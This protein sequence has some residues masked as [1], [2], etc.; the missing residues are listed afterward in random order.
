M[1]GPIFNFLVIIFC[2]LSFW[3]NPETYDFLFDLLLANWALLIFNM[4]PVF[5]L[6]AG[7]LILLFISLR[8]SRL[9][10]LRK[11]K[12]ISILFVCFL[13]VLFVLS[14]F[15]TFN[16]SLGV[17]VVNLMF[18]I[19]SEATDTSYKRQV[20][21]NRKFNLIRKGLLERCIY[22]SSD[23]PL[24]MLFKF[25]DDSHFY[26]FNFLDEN[27]NIVKQIDELEFYRDIGMI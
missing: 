20:F 10:A 6:D 9:I 27:Y 1:A 23:F 18:L 19:F 22:V 21:V 26:K 13:F 8:H 12:M 25:I 14:S 17:S 2:Y 7:R 4:I 15:Y 24:Y 5:P 11:T 3:F 16:F